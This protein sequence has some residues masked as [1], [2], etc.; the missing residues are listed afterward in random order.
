MKLGNIRKLVESDL[1]RYEGRTNGKLFLRKLLTEPGFQYI[2]W[3][4]LTAYSRAHRWLRFLLY[5]PACLM[6]KHYTVKYGIQIPYC[7][8]V[9][10]GF[11][12][13]HFG[14]I[15]VNGRVSIGRN[16][17]LSHGVTIGL[18]NR[19]SRKGW[20][21]IGD[22]VYIGPGAK[23]FGAVRIGNNVAIGANSVVTRDVPDNTVVVGIPAQVISHEGAAGYVENT[24]YD[25]P[26]AG[27][28]AEGS[29]LSNPQRSHA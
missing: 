18:S 26:E 24:A 9:G 3:M 4:R 15:V 16:C 6:L 22:N 25:L 21:T 10:P 28:D 11:Y 13:G 12:I 29:P 23:I 17:N 27:P 7:T 5:P 20:P 8:Q 19:G 2:F 14:G 1:Y